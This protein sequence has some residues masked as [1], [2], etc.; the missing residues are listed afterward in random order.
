MLPKN[1]TEIVSCHQIF[2]LISIV[3]TVAN[4]EVITSFLKLKKKLIMID[5]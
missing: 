1:K 2:M 5:L 4:L 3:A